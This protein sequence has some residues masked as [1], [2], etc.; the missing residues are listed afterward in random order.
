MLV[1]HLV[2]HPATSGHVQRQIIAAL[3]RWVHAEQ[4]ARYFLRVQDGEVGR[5]TSAGRSLTSPRTYTPPTPPPPP[6][7]AAPPDQHQLRA[8]PRDAQPARPLPWGCGSLRTTA[9]ESGLTGPQAAHQVW[10][11]RTDSSPRAQALQPNRD[12]Q[13]R[14]IVP[15]EMMEG[16]RRSPSGSGGDSRSPRRERLKAARTCTTQPAL[17]HHP[18]YAMHLRTKR[19]L[20]RLA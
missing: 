6:P 9:P 17:S 16:R 15:G 7:Q 13:N 1:S 2:Q 8:A 3:C 5:K 19:R 18:R 14:C 4:K 20:S 11:G 10:R 12:P